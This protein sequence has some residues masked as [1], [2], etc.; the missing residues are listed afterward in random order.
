M[1]TVNLDKF[2]DYINDGLKT[3]VDAIKQI[4]FLSSNICALSIDDLNKLDKSIDYMFA[5]DNSLAPLRQAR[6]LINKRL[7]QLGCPE[8]LFTVGMGMFFKSHNLQQKAEALALINRSATKG[9]K[10]AVDFLAKDEG[11]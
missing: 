3:K 5:I 1:E 7:A 9:Y 8:S 6:L 4:Q 11:Q 2:A 10:P